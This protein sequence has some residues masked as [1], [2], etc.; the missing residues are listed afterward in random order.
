MILTAYHLVV[1]HPQY[2][3]Q[4]IQGEPLPLTTVYTKHLL[5]QVIYAFL[6]SHKHRILFQIRHSEDAK[7]SNCERGDC[8]SM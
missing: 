8:F 5:K 7:L 2:E 1:V 4:E 3:Y 6:D